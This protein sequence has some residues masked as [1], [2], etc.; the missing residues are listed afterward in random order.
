MAIF[1][2]FKGLVN[3]CVVGFMFGHSEFNEIIETYF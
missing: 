1:S 2:K 3:P